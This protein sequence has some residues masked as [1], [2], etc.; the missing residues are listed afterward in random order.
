MEEKKRLFV[1]MDGTLTVFIPQEGIGPLYE[2]GYFL[3][4]PPHENVIEAIR[5]IIKKHP[6][7]E[8]N[9]LSAV[10]TD[11]KYALAE[12]NAWLDKYLPE[13]DAKHRIFSP[14][15]NDKK[16]FITGFKE[17]DVLLDDY[18]PNLLKWIPA[19]GIKLLNEINHTKGT[20]QHDR[21]RY[22]RE[23]VDLANE[24]V[25]IIKGL[26]HIYDEPAE[27]RM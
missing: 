25:S 24:I 6:E 10:L 7:I 13:I 3:N 19:R 8:V 20:W 14:N 15:G 9:V 16:A 23:P 11:S 2:K 21:I 1:D 4:L 17:N 5:Y 18:T 22:D 27:R 12:K 26:G